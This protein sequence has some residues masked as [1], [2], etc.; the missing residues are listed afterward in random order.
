MGKELEGDEEIRG[1]MSGGW[2]VI[3]EGQPPKLSKE[4]VSHGEYNT[5]TNYHVNE[6]L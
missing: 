1:G 3:P 2:D 5:D 6:L 4:V